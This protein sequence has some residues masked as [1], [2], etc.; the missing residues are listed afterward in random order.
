MN[1]FK[2]SW[3]LSIPSEDLDK[4]LIKGLGS[5]RP[6]SNWLIPLQVPENN[7]IDF[8]AH[9][10]LS[11]SVE[12]TIRDPAHRQSGRATSQ[13]VTYPQNLAEVLFPTSSQSNPSSFKL[14]V[15]CETIFSGRVIDKIMVEVTKQHNPLLEINEGKT[16]SETYKIGQKP[17]HLRE[18]L[19]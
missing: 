7:P 17:F 10:P 13:A 1:I 8:L 14:I 11:N 3:T 18:D 9:Y 5:E 15:K 6:V 12:G 19:L 2:L 4:I 16:Q